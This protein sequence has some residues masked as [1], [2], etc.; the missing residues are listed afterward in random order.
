MQRKRPFAITAWAF[1]PGRAADLEKQ[2]CTTLF[3]MRSTLQVGAAIFLWSAAL[4]I[5]AQGSP[6]DCGSPL[7]STQVMPEL[8]L[9]RRDVPGFPDRRRAGVVFST[10]GRLIVFAVD[11]LVVETHPRKIAERLRPSLL[12]L[13]LLDPASGKVALRKEERTRGGEAAV[14]ATTGGLLVKSGPPMELYSPDLAQQRDLPFQFARNPGIIVSVSPTGETIMFNDVVEGPPR[15][16]HSHF[17]VLDAR[18]LEVRYSWE[19]SPALYH[20]YSISDRGIAAIDPRSHL[21]VVSEFGTNRWPRVGK[22]FGICFSGNMPTLYSD[23]ELTYGCDRL[24]AVST[25]GQVLMTD[26]F[27]SRDTSSGKTAV[28]QA[29]R[30]IAVSVHTVKSKMDLLALESYPR[31]TAIHIRL[32]DMALKKEIFTVGV[33][34]LPRRYYD[35]ALSPDGSRLA[36]LNDREVT[37]WAVPV[38][39]TDRPET[40]RRET[41]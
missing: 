7:W 14:F 23:Q 36:V 34:P 11:D 28:A 10:D 9:G 21:I 4:V 22:P 31:V 6:P 25:E 20:S 13:L 35:L 1:L 38:Q 30:F 40:V 41:P 29:G 15:K 2:V 16:F 32:Y 19:E 17:D 27:P 37:V 39:S 8:R 24:V 5:G 12:R 26:V 33:S 3:S 18:T